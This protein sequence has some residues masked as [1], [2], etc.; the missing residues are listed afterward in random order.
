M[1]PSLKSVQ[2]SLTT[3]QAGAEKNVFFLNLVFCKFNILQCRQC[4]AH[5]LKLIF[6]RPKII[7]S[8]NII[9]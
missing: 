8:Q 9:T 6:H 3:V 5:D 2:P 7:Q 1:I 4:Y